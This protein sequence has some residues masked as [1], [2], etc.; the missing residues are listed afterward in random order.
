[1]KHIHFVQYPSLKIQFVYY[2]DE[3][4]YNIKIIIFSLL[5]TFGVLF[6]LYYIF[7]DYYELLY[8]IEITNGFNFEYKYAFI[9]PPLYWIYFVGHIPDMVLI[10][11]LIPTCYLVK[12]LIKP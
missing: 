5:I 4:V 8:T 10:L 3:V 1:M 7:Y 2:D 12:R 11:L 9:D 6:Y